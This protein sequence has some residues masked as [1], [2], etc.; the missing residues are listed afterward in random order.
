MPPQMC[1]ALAC[2]A[3]AW[4]VTAGRALTPDDIPALR[5]RLGS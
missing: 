5:D 2:A 1:L 3:G 4:F